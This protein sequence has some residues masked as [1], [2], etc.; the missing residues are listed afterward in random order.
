[1]DARGALTG[2]LVGVAFGL[3]FVLVNSGGLPGAWKPVLRTAAVVAAAAIVAI[4]LRR[5]GA[6][7]REGSAPSPDGPTGRPT[8]TGYRLIVLAEAIGLY[9]GVTILVRVFDLPKYAI[10][11]VAFV[12]GIHF[13]ALA[14]LWHVVR[15]HVIGAAL[16]ALAVIA[17]AIGL[18]GATTTPVR[19]VAGVG[20]GVVLLAFAL[21]A[22]LGRPMR[23]VRE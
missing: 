16:T 13:F 8:G 4:L 1:M 19:I 11:W 9:G 20:S 7:V 18:A 5:L 2:G 10:V 23:A 17:T 15:F 14:V 22:G 12:V 6:A 3:V 21:T